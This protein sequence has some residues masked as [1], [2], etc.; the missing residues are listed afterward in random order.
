MSRDT[1][2]FVTLPTARGSVRSTT[3]DVNE[4]ASAQDG[5]KG[6]RTM[7]ATLTRMPDRPG[8]G[9]FVIEHGPWR[10]D[11]RV[12][13]R[14]EPPT[15][16]RYDGGVQDKAEERAIVAAERRAREQRW[17]CEWWPPD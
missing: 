16:A 15:V 2:T 4:M 11:T 6:S 12:I 7:P 8:R 13:S 10:S 17:A 1:G 14:N 3:R 5:Q 9:S